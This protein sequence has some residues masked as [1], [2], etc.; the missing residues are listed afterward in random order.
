M[1][2]QGKNTVSISIV[3]SFFMISDERKATACPVTLHE[4]EMTT[5]N[6]TTLEVYVEQYGVVSDKKVYVVCYC[7]KLWPK[8][9]LLIALIF[10]NILV[11]W[12]LFVGYAMI[13]KT[14]ELEHIIL[15]EQQLDDS[16]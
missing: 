7:G 5:G 3:K 8:I 10:K 15:R 4:T 12:I 2:H 13:T 9:G 1:T 14:S 11:F 16:R 6:C